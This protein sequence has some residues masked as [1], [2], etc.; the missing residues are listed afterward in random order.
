MSLTQKK[1]GFSVDGHWVEVLG[2]TKTVHPKWS[3][4]ID[5]ETADTKNQSGEFQLS[6]TIDGKNLSVN[7]TQGNFGDVNVTVELNGAKI[8]E[9]SGFLL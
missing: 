8:Q 7:I 9:F 6:A 2:E 4:L 3:V 5:N 1:Y